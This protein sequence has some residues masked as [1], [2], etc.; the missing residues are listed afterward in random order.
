MTATIAPK[1]AALRIVTLTESAK[2]TVESFLAAATATLVPIK[3][4]G[5][6]ALSTV[7]VRSHPCWLPLPS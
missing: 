5:L 4:F 2:A 1:A 3:P 6:F 7:S